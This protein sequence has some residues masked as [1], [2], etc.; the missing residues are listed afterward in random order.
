MN[1]NQLAVLPVKRKDETDGSAGRYDVIANDKVIGTLW[2]GQELRVPYAA[3][4]VTVQVKVWSFKSKA[5]TVDLQPGETVEFECGQ[6]CPIGISLE[7]LG[8]NFTT[9][10]ATLTS[11]KQSN[12]TESLSAENN[13]RSIWLIIGTIAFVVCV[14]L[15]GE[16][17]PL[18]YLIVIVL[19]ILCICYWIAKNNH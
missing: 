19:A 1:Q 18:P 3:G 11:L 7:K 17:L 16:F 10:N 8:S 5:H 2:A 4:R 14:K 15:V 9:T 6:G 12:E 13:K